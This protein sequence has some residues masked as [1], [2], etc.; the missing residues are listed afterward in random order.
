[1]YRILKE[2]SL[3]AEENRVYKPKATKH[4]TMGDVYSYGILLLEMFTGRRPTEDMFKDGLS[5][6]KFVKTAL[7]DRVLEIADPQLLT[8]VQQEEIGASWARR[9]DPRKIQGEEKGNISKYLKKKKK[10]L[11]QAGRDATIPEKFREKERVIYQ[12][13][14]FNVWCWSGLFRSIPERTDADE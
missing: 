6:R 13:F 3:M 4:K 12:V 2:P 1:M 11:E 14:R 8:E 9:S 5:I 10:K 7:P